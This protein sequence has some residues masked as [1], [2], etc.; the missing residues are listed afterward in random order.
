MLDHPK[1][2]LPPHRGRDLSLSLAACLP[3]SQP[4][5]PPPGA[6]THA[7]THIRQAWKVSRVLVPSTRSGPSCHLVLDSQP[8][9]ALWSPHGAPRAPQS[10]EISERSHASP[11]QGVTTPT[12][13]NRTGS[14][15]S[16]HIAA[17]ECVRTGQKKKR[18]ETALSS[19][20]D[21]A[22]LFSSLEQVAER[23]TPHLSAA[24]VNFPVEIS[25][26]MRSRL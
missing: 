4:V 21:G 6:R 20:V 19:L 11:P 16:L 25:H 1:E 24:G 2:A 13:F 12:I 23:R 10:L 18:N 5:S 8:S 26:P 22:V 9:L 14:F 3:A 17:V 7:R 15:Q